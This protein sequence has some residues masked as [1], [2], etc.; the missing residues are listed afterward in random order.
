[1]LKL[2]NI[3]STILSVDYKKYNEKKD[4]NELELNKF[5]K[6]IIAI[7]KIKKHCDC[8]FLKNNNLFTLP[9]YEN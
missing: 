5:N 6:S 4:E 7:M 1:M 8:G 3:E 2:Y 9:E